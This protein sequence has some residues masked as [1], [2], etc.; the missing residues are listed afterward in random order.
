VYKVLSCLK[1]EADAICIRLF[2]RHP[3]SFVRVGQHN[4]CMVLYIF[5]ILARN[6]QNSEFVCI[7]ALPAVFVLSVAASEKVNHLR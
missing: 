4:M 6:I 5:L 3:P 1:R 2:Q 7:P